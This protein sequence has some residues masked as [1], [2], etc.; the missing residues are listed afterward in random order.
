MVEESSHNKN[1]KEHRKIERLR[2]LLG[3]DLCACGVGHKLC[4]KGICRKSH[5]NPSTRRVECP[6]M[7]HID[8]SI[9]KPGGPRRPKRTWKYGNQKNENDNRQSKQKR[10]ER[11]SENDRS[12]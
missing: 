11:L 4:C 6:E 8:H 5:I 3:A 1:K 10:R 7:Y 12:R 2:R 9:V